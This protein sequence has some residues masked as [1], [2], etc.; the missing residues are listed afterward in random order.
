M[1]S[2]ENHMR[3]LFLGVVLAA[4]FAFAAPA[5]RG[6]S[7]TFTVLP[8]DISGSPGETIG[9]GYSITNN[10]TTDYLDISNVDSSLFTIGTADNT[11]FIFSFVTIA[12]GATETQAYD[13]A[14]LLGLFEVAIDPNATLGAMDSGHFGLYGAFCDP[15][16]PTCAEKQND[17]TP[18]LLAKGDYSA[19]VTS[20][21]GT[22][23]PEPS[24]V[25]LL[26]SG[27]CGIG[28]WLWHRQR[29]SGGSLYLR[30]KTVPNFVSPLHHKP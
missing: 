29:V 1:Q 25:L 2:K 4:A 12:P 9:W 18:E 19:T 14:N 23:I 17:V 6:D 20:P 11:P 15:S 28:L 26:L 27:L 21:G 10:S 13:P 5:V 7:L 3:R 8:P 24:S 30:K 22:P 16:D